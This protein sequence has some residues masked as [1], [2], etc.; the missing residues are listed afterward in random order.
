MVQDAMEGLL[1]VREELG[2]EIPPQFRGVL[3]EI[4]VK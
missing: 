2:E 1:M 3:D 4:K